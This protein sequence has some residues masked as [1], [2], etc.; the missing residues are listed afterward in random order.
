[1][2]SSNGGL[3]K[4]RLKR[5]HHAVEG[6][7]ESGEVVGAITLIE[8]KGETHV[9]VV[10]LADRENKTPL[11]RDSIFRIASMSKP[12]TAAA[13]MIL[14]EEA[15]LRLDEPVDRLLPELANRQV[16]VSLEGPLDDT[17]P[18]VR[19]ITLRDLLTFR[20]GF[21][22]AFADPQAP[23]QKAMEEHKIMGLKPFPPHEPDEWIRHLGMLPLMHQPG[24]RWMYHTGSD[25]LGVLIARA[26]G[27]P[28]ET[29][30]KQRLFEPL[31]MK[32]TG[33]SVAPNKLDRLGACYQVNPETRKLELFDEAGKASQWAT[34]PAFPMG[35]GGLVS[36]IDDYLAFAR[37]MLNN[38]KAGKERILSRP[39]VLAMTTDQLTEQQKDASPF[40]PGFWSANGWG[41]GLAMVTGRNGVAASPGR[42]G[43]DGAFGTS[44]A[45]DPSED[46]T[47]I[48][49]QQRM[50]FG[51]SPAGLNS[52]FWTL[53]YQAIDD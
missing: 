32:D 40:F 5:L 12:I 49:M 29:F 9:D 47:C 16:L 36:T 22:M 8:R 19:P 50:G 24:A 7:V 18:A 37:M 39:S 4:S 11:K 30:L 27:L 44:W 21:G 48:L 2:S 33:F 31:G 15:K 53:A 42:F 52:D 13:A 26:S 43:W 17:V 20:M 46:M 41:F 34:P 3:S 28:F 35:G 23:I 1:M 51:P 25:V 38:G 10:G 45:S 14:V 6:Y